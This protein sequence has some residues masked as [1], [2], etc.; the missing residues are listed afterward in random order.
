MI[1]LPPMVA[2]DTALWEAL[3]DIAERMH[4][5]WTL[6]GGQMVLLHALEGGRTPP[7]VSEDL[8]LVVDARIRPPALPTMMTVLAELR[9]TSVGVSPDGVAHRFARGGVSID[10]LA[11]DGLGPRADLRTVGGAV[12]I[13]VGGGT[14]ALNETS[15][16]DVG[17]RGRRGRVP[18]PSLAGSLVVKAYAA[19]TD[20]GPSGTSRHLR[21]LAF[22]CSLVDDPIG[23]RAQLGKA[24]RRRLR[25]VAA[26]ADETHEAWV[27]LGPD[28][29]DAFLTW[30][31]VTDTS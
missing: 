8:D 20:R 10:V 24:N 23:L 7:R 15:L 2:R 5:D 17:C 25:D 11:P 29:R 14:Y 12:T 4:S 28:H 27:L 22:L 16:V 19:R 1:E 9:F 30:R 21:D 18:R 31:L 13:T 26:L 3:L 6:V